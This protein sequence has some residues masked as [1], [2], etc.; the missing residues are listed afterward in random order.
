MAP[1]REVAEDLLGHVEHDPLDRVA[2]GAGLRGD[3]DR[4]VRRDDRVV[5]AEADA[6]EF[7]AAPKL[8][9]GAAVEGIDAHVL[10]A[11]V[12]AA[13]PLVDGRGT[14]NRSVDRRG[15][16]DC[17]VRG[18]ECVELAVA[19]ADEQLGPVVCRRVP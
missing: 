11:D 14:E 4:A 1:A 3:Q 6:G 18:L 9:A 13:S 7:L 5:A 16:R 19:A 8:A 12:D 15:P 2:A 17:P 10:G